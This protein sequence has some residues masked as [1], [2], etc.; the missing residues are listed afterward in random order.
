MEGLDD[1]L[2][3]SD[4]ICQGKSANVFT[5]I[6]NDCVRIADVKEYQV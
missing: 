6:F 2:Q 3:W 5:G 4:E 1:Q